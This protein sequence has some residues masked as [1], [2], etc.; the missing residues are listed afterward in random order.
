MRPISTSTNAINAID[1]GTDLTTTRRRTGVED[2]GK[3]AT[4]LSTATPKSHVAPTAT[5]CMRHGMSYAPGARRREQTAPTE[6]RGT[7]LLYMTPTNTRR[8]TID[9]HFKI[10][11]YNVG[12]RREVMDSIL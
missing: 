3:K 4:S 5:N 10:M 6:A 9:K 8:T 1:T 2:A 7:P 12:K 11:Q